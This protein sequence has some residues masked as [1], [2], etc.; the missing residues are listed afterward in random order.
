MHDWAPGQS[1]SLVQPL[2]TLQT[3]FVQTWPGSGQSESEPQRNGG[4]QRPALQSNPAGQSLDVVQDVGKHVP[5]SQRS[6]IVQS[7]STLHWGR[8]WQK[9]PLQ[10][11][12][13]GH[14][15]STVH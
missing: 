15:A 2:G 7:E 3:L 1:A 4:V 13:A 11:A 9:K 12:P 6:P 8:G 10:I 14:S 5:R